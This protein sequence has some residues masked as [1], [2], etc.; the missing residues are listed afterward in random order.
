MVD[1]GIVAPLVG[2]LQAYISVL[3]TMSYGV[4]TQ[5]LRLIQESS[6]NDMA[7]LGV[8]LFLPAL[9]IINLR[10]QL[11]LMN[12]LNYIPVLVWS[13]IY[14]CASI[15]LAYFVSKG[16]KLPPWVTPACAFNNTTSLPLPLLQSLG[17]SHLLLCAM[18]SKTIG[19]A[20]GPKLLQEGDDP[21]TQEANKTDPEIQDGTT[22][23]DHIDE[24]NPLLP[25]RAQ[26]ARRSIS[27][28]IKQGARRTSSVLP[29]HVRQRLMAPFE[30][31]LADVAITCTVIGALIGL[32]PQILNAWLTLSIQNMGKL[33]TT[34]QIFVV[35]WKLGYAL[36]A[37]VTIFPVRLVIWPALG[38][39]V[40][41]SLARRTNH[42]PH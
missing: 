27:S 18:I 6:I 8:K 13:I 23:H 26:R 28:S 2:A 30:S 41:Y 33:F 14:T 35:G 37:I 32:L 15:G 36:K 20:V 31:P 25:Q 21:E 42:R 29:K 12:A 17:S 38:I 1:E 34:F 10:E 9:I 24:E 3:L 22:E 11:H 19:S 39:S 16:L 4:A 7:R 5:R 40:I